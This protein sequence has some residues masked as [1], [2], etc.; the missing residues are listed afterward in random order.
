M[1]WEEVKVKI[2]FAAERLIVAEE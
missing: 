2:D 1:E